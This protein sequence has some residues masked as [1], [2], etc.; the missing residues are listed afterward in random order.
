MVFCWLVSF[1]RVRPVRR[2]KFH[3]PHWLM[4]L[5][6]LDIQLWIIPVPNR[7]DRWMALL[8]LCVYCHFHCCRCSVSIH[9]SLWSLMSLVPCLSLSGW[10]HELANVN[11]SNDEDHFKSRL[12]ARL[13][14]RL[15]KATYYSSGQVPLDWATLILDVPLDIARR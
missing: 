10:G 11:Y 5:Q 12:S 2:P 4:E 15:S 14:A 13:S 1:L 6:F 9:V 8:R 7:L 3:S